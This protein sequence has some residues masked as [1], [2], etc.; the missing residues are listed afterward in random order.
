M[1]GL[2]E[3]DNSDPIAPISDRKSKAATSILRK[4]NG[5]LEIG[6]LK[7]IAFARAHINEWGRQAVAL[8]N[9]GSALNRKGSIPWSVDFKNCVD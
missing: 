3:T 1:S 6:F 7:E 4:C 2:D 8:G 9:F 5:E